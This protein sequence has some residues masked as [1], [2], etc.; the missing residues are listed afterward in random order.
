MIG[1]LI[2]VI[3]LNNNNLENPDDL[4]VIFNK[5]LKR[6]CT[7]QEVQTL[8]RHFRQGNT[9]ELSEM[10]QNELEKPVDDTAEM[11]Y[12]AVYDRVEQNLHAFIGQEEPQ[13]LEFK[14]KRSYAWMIAIAASVA[15]FTTAYLNW[16]RVLNTVDPIK[17][18]QA[19]TAFGERRQL[20]LTDGT[21]I[22]IG[23]GSTL[24][25]PAKFRGDT[26]EIR[27]SGEAYLEVAHDAVH[28]FIVHTAKLDTRVL[29]TSFDVEAYA[30]QADVKVTLLT[31]KVRV[32]ALNRKEVEIMPNE[33]ATFNPANGNLLK[34]DYPDAKLFL[35][36]REGILKYRGTPLLMVIRDIQRTFNI[37]IKLDERMYKCAYVGTFRPSDRIETVMKKLVLPFGA[38][39]KQEGVKSYK[40]T[41]KGC[42]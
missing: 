39:S 37:I 11:Q 33:Q 8:L 1:S 22:W 42:K 17:Q 32:T 4:K 25:Y 12:Q 15:L 9:A 30:D 27:V 7:P 26:R 31:G 29:G 28:P 38:A 6:E 21:Q 18:E 3:T 13:E 14:P 10:V 2:T 19:S 24:T 16:T 36:R 40:I 5:Y 23:P 20:T 34:A 41:G 35:D